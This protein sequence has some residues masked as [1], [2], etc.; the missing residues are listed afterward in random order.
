MEREDGEMERDGDGAARGRA[1]REAALA[2]AAFAGRDT[3][4]RQRDRERDRETDRQT[5]RQNHPA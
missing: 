5:D 3:V 2:G 4:E 1:P